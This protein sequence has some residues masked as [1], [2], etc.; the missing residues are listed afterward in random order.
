MIG[1][2]SL[3]HVPNRV[4]GHVLAR[5]PQRYSVTVRTGC[6]H[7]RVYHRRG[8]PS[9]AQRRTARRRLGRGVFPGAVQPH[10]VSL[11]PARE[12][13]LL[14]RSRL[15]AVATVVPFAG[16][17]AWMMWPLN[18]ATM[19]RTLNSSRPKGSVGSC[20]DPARVECDAAMDEVVGDV[21]GVGDGAGE[22]VELSDG[23]GVAGA[24]SGEGFTQA[25]V[26]AV[27]AGHALVDEDL[28]GV[29]AEPGQAVALG[30]DVL[31]EGGD[32]GVLDL[33]TQLGR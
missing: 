27:G 19:A 13:R 5:R 20:T 21:V 24:A 23:E 7:S 26:G 31:L 18:W 30:G 3:P 32:P 28:G 15:V 33:R 4:A 14:L 8:T 6:S 29:D 10:Q 2:R 11:P 25:G 16:A 9:T 17:G 1:P 12:L 22:A